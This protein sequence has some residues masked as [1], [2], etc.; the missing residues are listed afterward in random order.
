MTFVSNLLIPMSLLFLHVQDKVK[1]S[2]KEEYN[3]IIC[4]V[5][6]VSIYGAGFFSIEL[7][8]S[9]WIEPVSVKLS[10]S[11]SWLLL[12]MHMVY[13]LNDILKSS[14]LCISVFDSC[15]LQC[16]C[17]SSQLVDPNNF[18]DTG[19]IHEERANSKEK[20]PRHKWRLN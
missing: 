2:S 4:N 6:L 5:N 10:G 19:S 15:I 17:K 18:T 7:A 11:T 1:F 14:S 12:H 3:C 8:R 9:S 13:F 16:T 20:I